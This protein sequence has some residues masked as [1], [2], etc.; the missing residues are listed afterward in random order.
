MA[1]ELILAV[2]DT[3]QNIRLLEAVLLPRGY[4]VESA[5][6]GAE[7]LDKLAAEPPDIVLLD[8][9]MPEMDGYAVCRAIRENPAT[10][11]LPVVMITA[12]G[13]QE[14]I[15]AIEAGA[16]DF[17]AKPFN[18]AELLAR[19]RS[20]ARIKH[21][22]DTVE[23]Q[24]AELAQWNRTLEQR[25]HE[26]VA[27]IGRLG[28][29]R[30]FLS[31]SVAEIVASGGEAALKSHRQQVAALFCDLRGSTAFS[32]NAEPEEAMEVF[33]AYH[34][35]LGELVFRFDGTIDHR[36]GDGMMVIF[37]DPLPCDDPARRAVELALAMRE[38]VDGLRVDWQRRG[39]E[40][41]FGVGV[42]VGYATLGMV[43]F[44][45]RYDYVAN[46][47]VVVLAQRL[48]G[49]AETGQILVSQRVVGAL[50]EMLDVEPVGEL[51]LKGL[52]RPVAAFNVLGMKA[53]AA[54]T[55]ATP[56]K[57]VEDGR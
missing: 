7:A 29:L 14:K 34:E 26:Q 38:R 53:E 11:F 2:D 44:E 39:H 57:E 27:E 30:R 8:I 22:H 31:P 4:R 37:N 43:G 56:A 51:A 33:G 35:A 23:R 15:R 16:D 54:A 6:S 32:E 49:E 3:A 12:S 40:L 28:R 20:L 41:G 45:G 55:A 19:V 21:Y 52:P 5:G 17:I 10:S 1:G 50:E 9:V 24:A 25:V 47:S 48:G 46:G 13:D 18:Q 36:A 42:S